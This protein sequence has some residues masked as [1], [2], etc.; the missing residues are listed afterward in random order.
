LLSPD[1]LKLRLD[2]VVK[3]VQAEVELERKEL[4]LVSIG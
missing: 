2:V 3:V 4:F 1:V